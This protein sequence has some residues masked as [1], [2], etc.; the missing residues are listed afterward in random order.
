MKPLAKTISK[1]ATSAENAKL[2]FYIPFLFTSTLPHL[3]KVKLPAMFIFLHR[4]FSF[5]NHHPVSL[6]NNTMRYAY[7]LLLSLII[8]LLATTTGQAQ[9]ITTI[10]GNGTFGYSGDNGPA[11]DASIKHPRDV[12]VDD[13]GNVYIA[14]EVISC[15]R[16]IDRNGIITTY[17]GIGNSNGFSGDNG[18]ATNA[19]MTYCEGIGVDKK[20]NLY[21]ADF[22]N[23]R[24]R[25]VDRSGIITT[26]AGNGGIGYTGDNGPA[27]N[28]TMH[29]P[30]DVA[31][32]KWGNVYFT[33]DLNNCVRKIDTFGVIT[34]IAGTGMEGQTGNGGPATA[35]QISRPLKLDTDTLG[36]LYFT[37]GGMVRKIDLN[38]IITTISGNGI[39]GY[40]GDG[41]PA[42]AAQTGS[43]GIAVAADGEIY[44]SEANTHCIRKIDNVGIITKV[45]G[46]PPI[47]GFG[48]DGTPA[49]SA[50]FS[51]TFGVAIDKNGDLYIADQGNRRI[52]KT[53]Q[54]TV[55]I[56]ATEK[57]SAVKTY[58]S[59]CDGIFQLEFE[60]N[61]NEPM[62]LTITDLNGRVVWSTYVQ[63]NKTTTINTTLPNGLYLLYIA[64][65]PAGNIIIEH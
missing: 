32:D 2:H 50:I 48:G 36:N 55:N 26:I 47:S 45:A 11:T 25:K 53:Y 57:P 12:A 44:V 16:R 9:Y 1:N 10:A 23:Q 42:T 37:T 54:H 43:E 21:I 8:S 33:D 18:P 52:R 60:A 20:G 59:P 3:P 49:T 14:D 15:I 34:T 46:T 65:V 58:P 62:P 13:S 7:L 61:A 27:T 6:Y 29:D 35:A 19:Q 51:G 30:N 5:Y 22:Y 24:I 41:G 17:A 64:G 28:A 38:G 63:P 31:C 4:Q 40:S 39:G 56:T